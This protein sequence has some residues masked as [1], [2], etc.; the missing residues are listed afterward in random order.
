MILKGKRALLANFLYRSQA[1][2]GL[3]Y[4]DSRTLVIFN[5]HRI[6]TPGQIPHFDDG[7]FGPNQ[8]ELREQLRWIKLNAEVISEQD[9]LDH[10]RRRRKLPRSSV[11]VTFDDGYRDNYDLALPV[12]EEFRIP[13]IFF[14][15]TGAIE[16]REVGWWDTIAYL[17][18]RSPRRH[19]SV[20]GRTWDL[21][22]ERAQAIR[23]LQH[24]MRTRRAETTVYF[25]EELSIACDVQMPT[26][27]LA[28]RELMTWEQVRDCAA[29]GIAI[30]SHTHTHRVL[31]TLNLADQFEEFRCSKEL[32]EQKLERPIYSVAYP[33]GGHI[34]CHFETSGLAEQCGYELGFSFQTG[35][36]HLDRLNPFEI[37]RISGE[38]SLA[39]TAAAVSL[40]SVF[41]R[42]QYHEKPKSVSLSPYYLPQY[43]SETIQ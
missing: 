15:A 37:G 4:L 43:E 17:V 32:L 12:L 19:L 14:V 13:A 30:G 31:S 25:L 29:R 24:W 20:R 36:N 9:L 2:R 40:P 5:F 28:S 42:S 1:F 8:E 10:V 21:G 35:A 27:D 3:R 23:D 38:D 33:V 6:R 18:K 11:M 41:A 7:V 26:P 16:N 39:L 34:D 22:D